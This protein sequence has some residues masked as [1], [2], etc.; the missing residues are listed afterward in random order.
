MAMKPKHQRL[1][2]ALLALVAIIGAGLLAAYALRDE[3]AYFYTPS[4]LAAA[5]PSPDTAIRLGGMVVPGSIRRAEDGVTVRFAV[6]DADA[7]QQAMYRGVTPDLFVENSGVVA[8]GRLRADGMF[9][10]DTLLA[11][12]DAQ[13]TPPELQDMDI[14]QMRRSAEEMGQ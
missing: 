12:H 10:A 2:L 14:E 11:K 8:E 6:A 3:A 1:V 4:E 9:V 13:H 5:K 7:E